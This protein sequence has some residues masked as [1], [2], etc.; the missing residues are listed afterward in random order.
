MAMPI[1]RDALVRTC[2]LPQHFYIDIGNY[3]NLRCPFCVTGARQTQAPEGFMSLAAFGVIFDRIKDHARLI[4][5]YNWGEPLMNRDLLPII[6]LAAS[7]GAR[8][9]IDTN[10]SFSDLSDAQCEEIVRSVLTTLFASIDG[11]SQE[12]YQKYR[13]RG[14]VARVFGNLERL[15]EAKIRLASPTPVLGWQFHVHAFNEHEM[16]AARD[17]AFDLG[18][19]IVFKRLNAP[20]RAWHSSLHDQGFMTLRGERW[21]NQTYMPPPNPDFDSA[22]LHPAVRSPCSQMFATMTVAWNGSVMPCTCVEGEGHAMGNLFE[23]SLEEI[24]NGEAFARS[25]A[26]ILGYGPRQNGGSAC[27]TLAC[28]LQAKFV[29][30]E[31][32]PDAAPGPAAQPEL[33]TP[34]E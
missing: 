8:V 5:L 14:R 6:R 25:R 4:S 19:G 15:I 28:P 24:W 20:D 12:V 31:A 17:K 7:R 9:H 30:P 11:V 34:A 23:Q 29:P 26:F 33:A 21:F 2:R 16:Q 22:I 1:A 10:L 18:I 27:E 32:A 13:V 3:C